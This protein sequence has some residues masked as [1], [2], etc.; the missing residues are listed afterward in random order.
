[1]HILTPDDAAHVARSFEKF[2]IR[3]PLRDIESL[4][5]DGILKEL[6]DNMLD[7]A[8][9]YT[10]SICAFQRIMKQ[11][12]TSSDPDGDREAIESVRGSKHDAF[13]SAVNILSRTMVRNGKNNSWRD[14][15]GEDRA[16]L[17]LFALTLSF[18][19]VKRENQKEAP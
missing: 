9:R 3:V 19:Y 5:G 12:S 2:K 4:C 18:E 14:R 1:M 8:L 16:A 11:A 7:D 17:G 13:I 15:V 10:E 6:F